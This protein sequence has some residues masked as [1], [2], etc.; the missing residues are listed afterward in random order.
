MLQCV[1]ID[2]TGS[3]HEAWSGT[4]IQFRPNLSDSEDELLSPPAAKEVQEKTSIWWFVMV[5][6]VVAELT[7]CQVLDFLL[8]LTKHEGM[9]K[10]SVKFNDIIFIMITSQDWL[11]TSIYRYLYRLYKYCNK[12]HWI[13][14]M[15][16]L[17]R[18]PTLFTWS[19]GFLWFR[20]LSMLPT[21]LSCCCC[22]CRDLF[23]SS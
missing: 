22:C 16:W 1:H 17:L 19:N 11:L 14:T 13:S 2:K 9:T 23:G 7:A 5:N 4:I 12:S 10:P 21:R 8:W 18:I 15:S 20:V 6:V 3:H